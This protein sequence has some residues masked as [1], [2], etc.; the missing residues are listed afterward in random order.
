M[1]ALVGLFLAAFF[2]LASAVLPW[3][4]MVGLFGLPVLLLVGA[5]MPTVLFVAALL[6]LFGI[7]PEFIMAALPLGGAT[8]RPAE[9][10]LIF[11]FVVVFARVLLNG[12]DLKSLLRP[13]AWPLAILVCGFMLGMVKGK[14]LSNNALALADARQYVGWLALPVGLWFGIKHPGRLER[15]VIGVA[16]LAATLM[17]LQ[18]GLGVQL[19]FGFRGAEYLSKDFSDV[20]RS[21]IGGGLFFLGYAAY[22]LFLHACDGQRWRW[23]ALLGSLITIGGIVASFNRAIWAGFAVGALL[24][25]IFKP[26]TRRSAFL[27]FVVLFTCVCIGVAGLLVAKPRAADAL[28]ERVVSIKDEGRRGSSLGFRFDENQQALEALRRSPITGIGMGGEY[29]RVY[30]QLSTAGSFDT[31]IAFIHNGYLSLWL[32]LGIFGLVFPVFLFAAVFRAYRSVKLAGSTRAIPLLDACAVMMTTVMVF[33]SA[34]TSP[35]WSQSSTVAAFAALLA[36]LLG[37]V[38]STKAPPAPA[39]A[40]Q[41]QTV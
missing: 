14:V 6:L 25:L 19:I 40:L 39:A 24:L 11:C 34:I 28:I 1:V 17:I 27:P 35:D 10:V 41:P 9:L 36:V 20:T 2:G 12:I 30:R 21:A 37:A 18:L 38:A 33:V 31:E 13:L 4:F 16:L 29:K 3:Q 8:L 5:A 7:M 15:I 23:T 22:R 26:R 32:K